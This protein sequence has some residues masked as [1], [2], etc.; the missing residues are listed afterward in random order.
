MGKVQRKRNERATPYSRPSGDVEMQNVASAAVPAF[1]KHA[2]DESISDNEDA[3]PTKQLTRAGLLR[4]HK[5]ELRDFRRGDMS[6]M[7]VQRSKLS[8]RV[9]RQLQD[10]KTLTRDLRDSHQ[11]LLERHARELAEFELR[12]SFRS[13]LDY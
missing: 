4:R 13:S 8:K 1:T 11:E 3:A 2:I 5:L 9:D 6:E 10:R 12:L 7:K